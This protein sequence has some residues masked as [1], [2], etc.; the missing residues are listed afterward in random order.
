MLELAFFPA[1]Q[2]SWLV[3]GDPSEAVR[4]A[5]GAIH[6]LRNTLAPPYPISEVC[7]ARRAAA[8]EGAEEE[9]MA[10]MAELIASGEDHGR[11]GRGRKLRLRWGALKPEDMDA[12]L[13]VCL[14][15]P[16]CWCCR[17]E[18][19]GLGWVGLGCWVGLV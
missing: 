12:L 18:G 9:V 17:G 14:F 15:G 11:D 13:Q 8:A 7:E 5:L 19:L 10:A 16:V 4:A 2:R 3:V 1:E 6:A